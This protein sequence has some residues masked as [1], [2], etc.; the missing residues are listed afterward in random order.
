M[1]MKNS[2]CYEKVDNSGLRDTGLLIAD[3]AKKMG[4]SENSIYAIFQRENR[5][6]KNPGGRYWKLSTGGEKALWI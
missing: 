4:R 3:N 5:I 2:T 1:N 6:P